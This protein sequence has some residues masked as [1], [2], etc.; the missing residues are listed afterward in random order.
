MFTSQIIYYIILGVTVVLSIASA[1]WNF[2]TKKKSMSANIV[3]KGNTKSFS[4]EIKYKLP[5]YIIAAEQFYNSL[6]PQG[7]QKTGAQKLAYVLDKIK[8]DCLSSDVEY[9]EQ[10]VTEEVEKLIDLTKQ[11][12]AK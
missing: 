7:M 9:N 10:D 2:F 3:V 6:V 5:Q 11:V 12:N 4:Q 8:I 1:A